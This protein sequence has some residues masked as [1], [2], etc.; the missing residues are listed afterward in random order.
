MRYTVGHEQYR[1]VIVGDK[2]DIE[3]AEERTGH[4]L[5]RTHFMSLEGSHHTQGDYPIFWIARPDNS[6]NHIRIAKY[7]GNFYLAKHAGHPVKSPIEYFE[8]GKRD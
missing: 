6:G 5:S 1:A 7:K 2:A 8:S 4:K 3:Y